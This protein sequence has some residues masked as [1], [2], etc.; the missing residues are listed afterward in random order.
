MIIIKSKYLFYS[1]SIKSKT[2][3]VF[4]HFVWPV[5]IAVSG[6]LIYPVILFYLMLASSIDNIVG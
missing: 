1:F 4:P 6:S 3:W 2:R 5:N